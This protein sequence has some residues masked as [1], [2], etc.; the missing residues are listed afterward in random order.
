[1]LNKE[2]GLVLREVLDG[3]HRR[4]AQLG[5]DTKSAQFPKCEETQHFWEALRVGGQGAR[6]QRGVNVDPV[7]AL[8]QEPHRHPHKHPW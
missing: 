2:K 5:G 3:G 4:P 1:M 6:F 7:P 8:C